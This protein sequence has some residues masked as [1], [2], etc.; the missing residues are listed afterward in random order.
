[1]KSTTEVRNPQKL[2]K[3]Y[4]LSESTKSTDSHK[5]P[6]QAYMRIVK[7]PKRYVTV[8]KIQIMDDDV[9]F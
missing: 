7:V 5:N 9:K 1:M 6:M 3:K 2:P 8:K 4:Q